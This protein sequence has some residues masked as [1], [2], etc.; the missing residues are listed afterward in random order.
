VLERNETM[1]AAR[2]SPIM[3]GTS[4]PLWFDP[5]P[6]FAPGAVREDAIV[7]RS[8]AG[9][10]GRLE[11][12]AASG[13]TPRAVGFA[14][15]EP[16]ANRELPTMAAAAL[17]RGLPVVI[18]TEARRALR[19]RAEALQ[20]L[21]MAFGDR[22]VIRVRLPA[23]AA[24]PAAP[25]RGGDSADESLLGLRWLTEYGFAVQVAC[26]AAEAREP[27]LRRDFAAVFAAHGVPVDAADPAQLILAADLRAERAAVPAD[28][29]PRAQPVA[30][31]AA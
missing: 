2:R 8:A 27:A 30:Q 10:A 20:G 17:E 7:V 21:R 4:A 1:T 12:L 15:A 14:G 11:A 25:E 22:L 28:W 3:L 13:R 19:S 29:R 24:L 16:F 6:P 23:T 26:R 9:L 31:A 18:V 5:C